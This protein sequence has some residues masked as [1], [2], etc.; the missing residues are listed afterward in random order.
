MMSHLDG[1]FFK[2]NIYFPGYAGCQI[3]SER[4]LTPCQPKSFNLFFKV[5]SIGTK[6]ALCPYEHLSPVDEFFSN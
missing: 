4:G 3:D 1:R 2:V 5:L 6:I